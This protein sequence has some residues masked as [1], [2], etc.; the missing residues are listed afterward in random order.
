LCAGFGFSHGIDEDEDEVNLIFFDH[1]RDN[2]EIW[3]ILA[4]HG[5]EMRE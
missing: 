3:L 5:K 2:L 4:R 1:D